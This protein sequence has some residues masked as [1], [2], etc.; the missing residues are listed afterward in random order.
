MKKLFAAMLLA[1]ALT[2][3]IGGSAAYAD[4]LEGTALLTCTDNGGG[5]TVDFD[6]PPPGDVSPPR[7]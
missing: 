7:D 2:V 5:A 4:C 1:A 6:L 3:G